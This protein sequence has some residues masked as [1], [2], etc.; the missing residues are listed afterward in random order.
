MIARWAVAIVVCLAITACGDDDNADTAAIET[1]APQT[2]LPATTQSVDTTEAARTTNAV[3]TTTPPTERPTTTTTATPTTTQTPTTTAAVPTT[4]PTPTTLSPQL[5]AEAVFG[6]DALADIGCSALEGSGPPRVETT[7]EYVCTG[8]GG[9]PGY[10]IWLGPNDLNPVV[11]AYLAHPDYNEFASTFV[12]RPDGNV[13]VYTPSD[14]DFWGDYP[15]EDD[16]FFDRFTAVDTDCLG[17]P[18][19]DPALCD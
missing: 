18:T 7:E 15:F 19:D 12:F 16:G 3:N 2:A 10:L 8:R 5:R 14:Y 9:G 4:H 13:I 6:P 11:A 17:L 1:S